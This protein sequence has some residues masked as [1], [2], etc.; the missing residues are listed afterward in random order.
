MPPVVIPGRQLHH[1]ASSLNYDIILKVCT[2]SA[3]NHR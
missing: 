2:A 3:V 1:R